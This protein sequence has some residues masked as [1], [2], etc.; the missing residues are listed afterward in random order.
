[1]KIPKMNKIIGDYPKF[2]GDVVAKWCDI[3]HR[4]MRLVEPFS[5]IDRSGT[6]W[7]APKRALING[8]SIPRIFWTFVSSPFCGHYR[9][10]SVI[11]D[12]YCRYKQRSSKAVHL[13][14]YEAMLQD[15][16]PPAKAKLLYKAVAWF[17]PKWA[18]KV[19]RDRKLP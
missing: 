5:F 18:N 19:T 2:V 7:T 8:A 11:H 9:R 3:N 17:G 12:Y 13:M 14:F 10:A 16:V 1:M 15:G 6:K 4:D